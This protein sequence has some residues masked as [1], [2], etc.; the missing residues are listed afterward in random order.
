[1]GIMVSLGTVGEMMLTRNPAWFRKG[2]RCPR[3]G[4]DFLYSKCGPQPSSLDNSLGI[5]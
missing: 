2:H 1:M 3:A 5:G 4:I